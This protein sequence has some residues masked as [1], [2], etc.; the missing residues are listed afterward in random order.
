MKLLTIVT[1]LVYL[2][3]LIRYVGIPL[4]R[5]L[6]VKLEM[7]SIC[8]DV[9]H[10]HQKTFRIALWV[11]VHTGLAFFIGMKAYK[12]FFRFYSVAGYFGFIALA[13]L[14]SVI[15]FNTGSCC[16]LTLFFRNIVIQFVGIK[17]SGALHYRLPSVCLFF[18]PILEKL[19]LPVLVN[20]SIVFCRSLELAPRWFLATWLPESY[21]VQQDPILPS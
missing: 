15:P 1:V 8:N 14:F 16:C 6:K 19:C 3:L 10:N 18:K 11:T 12:E 7:L 9:S 20:E 5:S 13:Y 21:M 4:G 2:F 17:F